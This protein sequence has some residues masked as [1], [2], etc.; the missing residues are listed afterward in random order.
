MEHK[1]TYVL[2]WGFVRKLGKIFFFFESKILRFFMINVS[3]FYVFLINVS[4]FYIFLIYVSVFYVFLIC[5]MENALMWYTQYSS[6]LLVSY[7]FFL[8]DIESVV[9][10]FV[11]IKLK[12]YPVNISSTGRLVPFQRVDNSLVELEMKCPLCSKVY[13]VASLYTSHLLFQCLPEREYCF[14]C[15]FFLKQFSKHMPMHPATDHVIFV[16]DRVLE[17][18]S[19]YTRLKNFPS[20]VITTLQN[21]NVSLQG[22]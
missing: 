3:V 4:V 8:L 13:G 14:K 19:G 2:C 22:Q 15:G 12:A 5:Q 1:L 16:M 9:K 20:L 6:D 7:F 21:V 11:D 10:S 18:L 17:I